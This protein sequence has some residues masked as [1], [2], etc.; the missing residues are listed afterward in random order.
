M[1]AAILRDSRQ[2]GRVVTLAS[3]DIKLPEDQNI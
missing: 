1:G 3:F 2:L